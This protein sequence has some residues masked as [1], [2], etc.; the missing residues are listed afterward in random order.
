MNTR[1]DQLPGVLVVLS[2]PAGVGK[3]TIA[4]RLL[5]RGGYTRSVSATTRPKRTGETHGHDYHFVTVE[6]FH[7]LV[8]D[9]EL[10]EYAQLFDNYYGTPK[11]P[12]RQ[13]IADHQVVL[14]V[15]DVD[16]GRQVAE[17]DLDALLVFVE[18]P[19]EEEL[20]KRLDGRGTETIHQRTMR[21]DRAKIEIERA[22]QYYHHI[23]VNDDLDTCVDEIERLIVAAREKLKQRM[24]AGETLYPDLAPRTE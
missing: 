20:K 14:L 22:R 13:A 5:S 17:K 18:P 21:L 12:L 19:H 10:I 8:S 4:S 1:V 16:G 15:I 23:V 9:N 7:R 11:D 3:T 24:D 2:G 6:A